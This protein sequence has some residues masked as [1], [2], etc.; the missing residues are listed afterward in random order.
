MFLALQESLALEMGHM[1]LGTGG[2][3]EA[4][5]VRN[6]LES[7]RYAISPDPVRDETQDVPLALGEVGHRLL[8]TMTI[9]ENE[10]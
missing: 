8:L 2:A 5:G 6:F 9:G 7:R 10:A 1:L 4:E 3:A